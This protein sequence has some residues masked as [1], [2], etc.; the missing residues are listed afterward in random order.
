MFLSVTFLL[1]A[2]LPVLAEVSKTVSL[3][4][5]GT[6]SSNIS[7]SEKTTITNL[8][9]NGKI[10]SDDIA[11]M[12]DMA[13]TGALSV[14]DMS[15]AIADT[16][17][18][19][20]QYA[21]TGCNKLTSI[22]FP[23][24]VTSIGPGAFGYCRNLSSITIPYSVTSIGN[25]AFGKK[26]KLGNRYTCPQCGRKRCFAKYIDEEGQIV[27]PDNVGRC[28][29]EQSCGY[30]FS[31]SDYFKD[32]SDANCKDDWRYETPIKVYKK[33]KPLP[34]LI[35]SKLMEQTL[36]GYSVNPLYQYLSTVFGKEETE[37]LF[38]LYKVG[39]SKATSTKQPILQ[40]A[41][42]EA[43]ATPKIGDVRKTRMR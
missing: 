43:V 13:T 18:L 41:K 1:L 2:W 30:H 42:A 39:T 9:V 16:T 5:A 26:Y 3:T 15:S 36:H 11:T 8:T 19:I 34:T 12:K 24:G 29:H 40:K 22:S 4:E 27:F 38:A 31:P 37:R 7:D 17:C 33:E 32:N 6:L 28:D 10:N 21:F 23:Q 14:L 20:G 25:A 35:E